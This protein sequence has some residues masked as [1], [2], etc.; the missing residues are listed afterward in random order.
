MM[1]GLKSLLTEIA[2]TFKMNFYNFFTQDVC[3]IFTQS[4]EAWVN[5]DQTE[6]FCY[7]LE[8]NMCLK[9]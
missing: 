6:E 7:V 4:W 9:M 8:C 3:K 5:V 1:H 2:K